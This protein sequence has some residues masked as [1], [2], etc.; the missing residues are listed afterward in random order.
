M[1]ED[2][3]F[4]G[5]VIRLPD[6]FWEASRVDTIGGFV[7]NYLGRVPHKG[8]AFDIDDLHFEV[9]R[10]DARRLHTLLVE[11]RNTRQEKNP[12]KL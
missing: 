10:A 4:L 6:V 1:L 11:K 12:A 3:W 9:L 5:P 2:K 8:D 7:A